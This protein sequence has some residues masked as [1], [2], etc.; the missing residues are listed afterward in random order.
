MSDSRRP[1]YHRAGRGVDIIRG[2]SRGVQRFR[3]KISRFGDDARKRKGDGSG[4]GTEGIGAGWHVEIQISG[5]GGKGTEGIS[6][7]WHV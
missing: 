6:V 4:K 3:F 2:E 7:R 5:T 1:Q